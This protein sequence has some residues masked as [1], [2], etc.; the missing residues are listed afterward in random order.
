MPPGSSKIWAPVIP[1]L[2]ELLALY[3]EERVSWWK[4][5]FILSLK[6]ITMIPC[7]QVFEQGVLQRTWIQRFT[8][9][10]TWVISVGVIDRGRLKSNRRRSNSTKEPCCDTSSPSTSFSAA[11]STQ[12]AYVIPST[13]MMKVTQLFGYVH[14]KDFIMHWKAHTK[15]MKIHTQQTK[16]DNRQI[17]NTNT[18]IQT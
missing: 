9:V 10:F 11:C 1:E 2:C 5:W 17:T 4:K 14:P 18:I 13:Q 6:F 16:Q 15:K 12:A 8:S 7:C 3:H